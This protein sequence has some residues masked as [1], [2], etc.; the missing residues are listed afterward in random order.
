MEAT[1]SSHNPLR[2]LTAPEI[3][4]RKGR[5][6]IV[7]LTA[8]TAPIAE[9]LDPHVDLLLVGDSVGMVL[10]GQAVMRGSS[11]ALVVVDLP[12]GSYERS[13]Q[14]AHESAVTLMRKT[15]CQAVKVESGEGIAETISFLVERD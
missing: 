10:H 2:R 5:E 3:A 13:P 11:R 14:Q 15:G 8:Y 9:L 4:A 1:M 7:C 6:K 12:F